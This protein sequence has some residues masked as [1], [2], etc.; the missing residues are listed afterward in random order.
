MISIFPKKP[1][2]FSRLSGDLQDAAYHFDAI[3][4]IH[5]E[6]TTS[7]TRYPVEFGVEMSDHAYHEPTKITVYGYTGSKELRISLTSVNQ[8]AEFGASAIVGRIDNAI[9]SAAA[10]AAAGIVKA[11]SSFLA[12]SQNTR[13]V[14]TLD[15]LTAINQRFETFDVVTG[16]MGFKSMMIDKLTTVTTPENETGLE[17]ILEMSQQFV[18]GEESDIEFLGDDPTDIDPARLQSAPLLDQGRIAFA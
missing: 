2:E 4:K 10:G 16:L 18:V 9:L 8:L 13:G 14:A 17:F 15:F 3:V 11:N 5:A 1:L 6:Q 7:R 12:G